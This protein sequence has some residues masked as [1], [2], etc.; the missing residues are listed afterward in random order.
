LARLFIGTSGWVYGAWKGRF[1]PPTLPNAQQLSYFANHFDTTELNYSF[2]HVPSAETY[3]RWLSLV[4]PDFVFALKANRAITHVARLRD[5]GPIWHGFVK[6]AGTLQQHLGPI[7]LQLP[8]SLRKNH[9]DLTAFLEMVRRPS[10]SLRL[11]F[12]FRHASWF[13]DETYQLL[14]RYSAALCIA[15]S[16][17]YPRV[18][19]VTADFAYLRFHGR[20]PREAPFYTDEQLRHEAKF[21]DALITRGTDTYV[22]FN[23]DALAHAPANAV[24][25]K[26]FMNEL[27]CAA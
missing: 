7:L 27:R 15:D 14:R 20:M 11:V 26:Q 1:Y 22:Y 3:K 16:L 17:R 25:L 12:E 9:A 4:P 5:V 8:P 24:R 2:Y 23:N 21:V 6:A 13:T 10:R 18:D 19:K